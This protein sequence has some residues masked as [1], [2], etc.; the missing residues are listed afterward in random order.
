MSGGDFDHIS[1]H[2]CIIVWISVRSSTELKV[3]AHRMESLFLSRFNC[4]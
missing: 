2:F 1:I 4:L 3:T